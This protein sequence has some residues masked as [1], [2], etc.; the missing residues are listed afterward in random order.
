MLGM[1]PYHG[2]KS[3]HITCY[4]NRTYH[5]LLTPYF[6]HLARRLAFRY[7][8]LQVRSSDNL[9]S[10]SQ[11]QLFPL[12]PRRNFGLRAHGGRP[13]PLALSQLRASIS[14]L[15]CRCHPRTIRALSPLRQFRSGAYLPRTGRRRHAD[16]C[17]ALAAFS[18]LPLRSLPPPLLQRPSV[19]AHRSFI[20][21]K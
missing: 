20:R 12:A 6:P 3:G 18:R 19:P 16:P 11:R 9:S 5:V 2:P 1:V 13:A 7:P 21:R 8:A 14:R 4:L 10:V 17:E 15:A